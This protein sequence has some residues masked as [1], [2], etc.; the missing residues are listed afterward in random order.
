MSKPEPRQ[1]KHCE[2]CGHEMVIDGTCENCEIMNDD[3]L[4]PD[5][6]MSPEEAFH[7]TRREDWEREQ[8][9][10]MDEEDLAESERLTRQDYIDLQ[11]DLMNTWED[12]PD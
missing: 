9:R 3:R 5:E 2:Y 4:I 1:W 7:D 12:E 11:D 8:Y 6:D 10:W